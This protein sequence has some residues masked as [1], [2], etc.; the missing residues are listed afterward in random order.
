MEVPGR[1]ATDCERPRG[2]TIN[3]R[4]SEIENAEQRKPL[5]HASPQCRHD[6]RGR[7]NPCKGGAAAPLRGAWWTPQESASSS[8]TGV[9]VEF[10]YGFRLATARR[11]D[12]EELGVLLRQYETHLTEFRQ[13][14]ESAGR[15]VAAG[16]SPREEAL[17]VGELAAWTMVANLI[18]NLD[19]T[20]T[21]G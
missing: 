10:A 6:P 17:D 9:E 5:R 16:E 12:P 19:E 21:K 13:D 14:A 1:G 15:G 3:N 7:T 20:L 18:L 2:V 4:Q 8:G 11:P